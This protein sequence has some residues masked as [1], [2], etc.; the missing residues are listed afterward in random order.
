MLEGPFKSGNFV[1]AYNVSTPPDSIVT[2]GAWRL[3]QYVPG[4]KTAAT[5]PHPPE[6]LRYM[7]NMLKVPDDLIDFTPQL[8]AQALETVK[9][10]RVEASPKA[11]WAPP[12]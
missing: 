7:R 6:A 4:E 1:A 10:Y 12:G 9:K 2:S 8:R 11:N 5:P 3:K